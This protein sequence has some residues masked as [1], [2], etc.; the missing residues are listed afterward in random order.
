MRILKKN[1]SDNDAWARYTTEFRAF[2]IWVLITNSYYSF[3]MSLFNIFLCFFFQIRVMIIFWW[4]NF[5]VILCGRGKFIALY[6][7]LRQNRISEFPG[8]L[9]PQVR[10]MPSFCDRYELSKSLNSLN[11]V[12][13]P[14][15][16]IKNSTE[17]SQYSNI[18]KIR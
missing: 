16:L 12:P 11:S 5:W 4:I 2:F 15:N 1:V 17:K 14:S 18:I 10:R 6:Q 7:D 13:H 8:Q 3:N 9:K